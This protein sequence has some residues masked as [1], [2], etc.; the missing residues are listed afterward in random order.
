MATPIKRLIVN[1]DDFGLTEGI[2][3][4]IIM[5]YEKGIVNSTSLMANMPAFTHAA[6]FV[7]NS[8]NI[9]VG[10]HLNLFKGKPVSNKISSLVN[11]K[12]F[13]YTLPEFIKRLFCWKIV[14]EEIETEL[15][16]QIEKI[17]AAGLKISHLDSL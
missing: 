5:S 8:S 3:Q 4:G 17:L 6:D 11:K 14:F 2:N 13:F 10:V 15:E 12:G 7:R 1:A 16:M 9:A